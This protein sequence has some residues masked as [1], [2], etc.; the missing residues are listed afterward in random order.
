MVVSLYYD[1]PV[2]LAAV[3]GS[4][5]LMALGCLVVLL[6]QG[7]L[8]MLTFWWGD[9]SRL[10]SLFG[11]TGEFERYPLTLFPL[12]LRR[13]LTWII[14]IGLIST[15]PVLVYLGRAEAMSPYLA[16]AAALAAVWG[17]IFFLAWRRAL[18]RYESFGG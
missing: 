12:G 10:Q 5:A 18:A 17:L 15:Y 2:T 3:L 13:F 4:L 1:V 7:C 6:I 9:V 11:L 8:A 16:L 14:P